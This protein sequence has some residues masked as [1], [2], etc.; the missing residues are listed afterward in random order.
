MSLYSDGYWG[1]ALADMEMDLSP[2]GGKPSTAPKWLKA[3]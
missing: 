1:R 3:G 2:T